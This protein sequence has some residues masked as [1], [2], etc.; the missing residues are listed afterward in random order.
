MAV[1]RDTQAR[2]RDLFEEAAAIVAVEY[3]SELT[4]DQL[5]RRLFVSRRQLQR[6]FAEGAN[7]NFRSHL[8][9]VRMERALQLLRQGSTVREAARAVGYN[10]PAQFAKAFR[11]HHGRPPSALRIRGHSSDIAS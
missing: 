3:A 10:Q 11:R 9:R 4:L 5:A 8:C 2:R 7:G 6:A 1:R